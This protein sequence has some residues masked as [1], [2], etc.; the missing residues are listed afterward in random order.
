MAN[1]PPQADGTITAKG[2]S[3]AKDYAKAMTAALAALATDVLKEDIAWKKA[4]ACPQGCSFIDEW[5]DKP[6]I[7]VDPKSGTPKR[8]KALNFDLGYEVELTETYGIH[9]TCY[10]TEADRDAA[11]TAREVAAKKKE[12]AEEK[13]AREDDK[14]KK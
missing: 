9:R 13:K 2:S 1:C 8:L 10:K 5:S 7:T 3:A 11:K 14:Q 4:N 6:T 12:E